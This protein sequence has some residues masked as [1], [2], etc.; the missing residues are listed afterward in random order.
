[1][2]KLIV[3]LSAAGFLFC[4]TA[5]FETST[6]KNNAMCSYMEEICRDTELFEREYNAMCKEERKEMEEVLGAYRYQC[7]EAIKRC[8][9]S[10]KK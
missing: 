2:F 6:L 5:T 7:N 9:K 10:A 4:S 3:L 8:K 1:M